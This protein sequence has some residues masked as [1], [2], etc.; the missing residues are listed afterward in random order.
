MIKFLAKIG[1]LGLLGLHSI[2]MASSFPDKSIRMVVPYAAGGV[3]DQISRNIA[4]GLEKQLNQT[5][6]VDNKPGANTAIGARL[7]S[8]AK[9]DGYTILMA[10]GST[11]LLNPMMYKNLSYNADDLLPVSLLA[12]TPLVFAVNNNVKANDVESFVKLAESMPGETFSYAST[13]TGT[14]T[15]LAGAL[16]MEMAKLKA[17][18]VPFNGS[19]PAYTNLVGGQV[20]MSFDSIA[21]ALPLIKDGRIRPLA[22]TTTK[23]LDVLPD[24]PTVEEKGYKG[25]SATAWYVLALPK[26]TD[27]KIVDKY[28]T[29]LN[30]V[31]KDK[32]LHQSFS[33]LGVEIFPP[34][35]AEQMYAFMDMERKKWSGLIESLNIKFD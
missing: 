7:V 31:L 12:E 9:P 3:T 2:A 8:T 10:T 4:R 34:S 21:S 27:Q 17:N 1:L 5:V 35:N 26:G 11:L 30:E 19:M 6:V 14:S 18:H 15:H 32:S 20:D 24:T 33:N 13:G 29:A 22:V 25:Y 28:R 23:R 16:F